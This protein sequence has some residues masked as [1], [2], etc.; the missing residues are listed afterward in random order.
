MPYSI[1][2]KSVPFHFAAAEIAITYELLGHGAITLLAD[3]KS[4]VMMMGNCASPQPLE[5]EREIKS[6]MYSVGHSNG[7][8]E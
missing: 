2:L 7:N 6:V 5:L 8:Y 3:K 4:S 1:H